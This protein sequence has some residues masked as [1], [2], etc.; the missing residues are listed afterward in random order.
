MS[1][2]TMS[3]GV[4]RWLG[5]YT[6]LRFTMSQ[7]VSKWLGFD[8]AAPIPQPVIESKEQRHA[9]LL[10]QVLTNEGIVLLYYRGSCTELWPWLPPSTPRRPSPEPVIK[11]KEQRHAHLLSQVLTNE[12]IVLLYYRGNT[13]LLDLPDYRLPIEVL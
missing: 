5:V 13:G 11:N 12:G 1:H 7:W 9:H 4:S 10:S 8:P 2:Y 3:Q 6:S